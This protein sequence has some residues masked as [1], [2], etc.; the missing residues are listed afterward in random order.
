[1]TQD[2]YPYGWTAPPTT[3]GG[4]ASF[5]NPGAAHNIGS[6]AGQNSFNIGIGF[7]NHPT[8]GS[9]H[10]DFT[11]AEIEAGLSV[12]GY[13]ELTASG[14]VL[15]SAHPGGGR[16]SSNTQ[17]ARTEYRELERDGTTKMAFNP[18]QGRHYIRG[19]S[20]IDGP[21]ATAKPETCIAQYHDASDDT[22]MIHV[23]GTDVRVKIRGTIVATIATGWTRGTFADWMIECL[24]GTV[25]VYWNNMTTPAYS[26]TTFSGST[27]GWYGKAG[28]YMQWNTSNGDATICRVRLMNFEHWHTST[29]KSPS[30]WPTPSRPATSTGGTT[31]SG[32]ST[33]TGSTGGSTTSDDGVEAAKL[34]GWG[35]PVAGDE[36]AYSGPPDSRWGMYDGPG[37]DGN[38]IRTPRAFNVSNGVLTCTGDAKGNTGGMA[39]KY[40]EKYCRVEARIRT[41]SI[42]PKGSGKR[43]H[44]VLIYWPESDQWPQGGEFDFFETDCDSGLYEAF[45]HIPGNSGSAQEYVKRT[46]DISQWSNVAFEWRSNGITG[47]LNGQQVFNFPGFKNPPGPMHF[48]LQLD[49]FV[50]SSGLEPATFQCQWVRIY[51]RPS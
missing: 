29:P 10:R 19:R 32:G 51:N 20:M 5:A 48:C 14:D 17:Y 3:G 8:Y 41:S 42:N 38:G 2:P 4:S 46:H 7:D 30:A 1:M 44:P 23:R 50:G 16:T 11:R 12:P 18:S 43:Y 47:W 9:T 37:H 6:A 34:L 35:A 25:N 45:L 33:G 26:T 31:G 13:Y 28:D 27:S 49:N 36:F 22:V 39:L 24:N 15:M 21:M 40:N